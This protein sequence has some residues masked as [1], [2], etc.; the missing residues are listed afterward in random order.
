MKLSQLHWEKS[1]FPAL[2]LAIYLDKHIPLH[3][4]GVSATLF[5]LWALGEQELC[6]SHPCIPDIWHIAVAQW[7]TERYWS[8]QPQGSDEINLL[9]SPPATAHANEAP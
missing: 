8:Y 2:N 1:W 4:S 5:S 7:K 3:Y 9:A 6:N